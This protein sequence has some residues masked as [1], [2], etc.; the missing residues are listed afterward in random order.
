[1]LLLLTLGTGLPDAQAAE[2]L[3]SGDLRSRG[4]LYDSLSLSRS[5]EQSEGLSSW[6]DHRFRLAPTLAI[7]S[8]VGIHLQVDLL[9]Y[10]PWG[11]TTD[12]WV[13]PVSGDEVPLADAD[14]V[15]PYANPDDGGSYTLNFR[16]SRAYGDVYTPWARIQFGR[17]PL[18]W[19]AGLLLN[20][21]DALDAEYGDTSDRLQ[22]TTRVGPI[23]VIG[24]LDLMYEGYL[25]APDDMGVANL[26][27]L[28]RTETV[29]AGLLN[30]YRF[31]PEQSFQSY[32]A[33]AWGRAELGPFLGETEWVV[34]VGGGN[35]DTGANDVSITAWGG[36]ARVSGAIPVDRYQVLG[37]FEFGLASGDDTDDSSLRTFTF[38][39]DYNVALVMFEEPLP[40]LAAAVPNETNG[41]REY[42]A[43]VT[44]DAVSNAQYLR[45]W[46]GGVPYEGVTLQASWIGARAAKLPAD[47]ESS[48]RGY[49]N[50]FDL[51]LHWSPLDHF[52]VQ[53]TGALFLPGDFYANYEDPDFGGGFDEP[54]YAGRLVG[55]I[56]F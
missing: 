18:H 46:L 19:G 39:R 9:P 35:L 30:R 10:T 29:A 13:D 16:V 49:G 6:F 25:G 24:A 27:V 47:I 56:S 43:V 17:M 44:G 34:V 11:E 22:V 51:D 45:A 52:S 31:Q 20:D 42:G 48:R 1:M 23:Y 12:T 4:L 50:E 28:Y 2:M 38:D 7:S 37:G 32:T 55:S 15:V 54:V 40:T 21:G 33:D 41:G 53:L 8:S 14:G 26:A 36:M 3:W 5:I